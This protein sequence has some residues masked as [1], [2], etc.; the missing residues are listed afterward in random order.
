M[1]TNGASARQWL[2]ENHN[3]VPADRIQQVIRSLTRKMEDLG[4]D[5]PEWEGLLEALDV[6]ESYQPGL[7]SPDLH[8]NEL[9]TSPLI[10]NEPAPEPLSPEEKKQRFKALL[11]KSDL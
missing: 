5:H 10:A 6:L 4:E 9:D 2:E 7:T 11:Q 8:S 3:N 1:A